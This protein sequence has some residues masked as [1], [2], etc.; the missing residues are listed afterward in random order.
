MYTYRSNRRD[1]FRILSSGIPRKPP[2]RLTVATRL[3]LQDGYLMTTEPCSGT[4]QRCR[5]M[6]DIYDVYVYIIMIH[7]SNV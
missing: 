1:W 4:D 5:N 7:I 3:L 2:N 6:P